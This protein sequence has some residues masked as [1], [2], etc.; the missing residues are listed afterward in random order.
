MY[1][2]RLENYAY[3]RDNNRSCQIKAFH[4]SALAIPRVLLRRGIPQWSLKA[5][6]VRV[7]KCQYEVRSQSN[8]GL[9]YGVNTAI[10]FCECPIGRVGRPCKH[11]VGRA[12]TFQIQIWIL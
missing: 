10:G 2:S 4:R 1:I 11:Q 6:L 3:N 7:N 5:N 8:P 12:L 9:V